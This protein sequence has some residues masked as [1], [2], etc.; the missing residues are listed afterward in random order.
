MRERV[1]QN[2]RAVYILTALLFCTPWRSLSFAEVRS[3]EPPAQSYVQT[4]Q[5]SQKHKSKHEDDYLIRGTVFTPVGL[6]FPG[7]E[8][9]IRRSTEKKF[10]WNTY[11]NS[12]GEFAVRVKQGGHYEV[13]ARAKGF[14]DESQEVDAT[15]GNLTDD[16]VF[17]MEPKGGKTK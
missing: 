16:M 12:R 14:R 9:R 3:A 5:G 1:M 2:L 11:T 15:S 13:L 6:S 17:R 7:A 4:S 8:V 10:R